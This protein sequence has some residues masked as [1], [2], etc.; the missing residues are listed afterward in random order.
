MSYSL[1]LS[2]ETLY[3]YPL[4]LL[5]LCLDRLSCV[6]IL[7]VYTGMT[8]SHYTEKGPSSSYWETVCSLTTLNYLKEF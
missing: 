2:T 4:P 7:L 5:S 8:Q 6:F 1:M 3:T